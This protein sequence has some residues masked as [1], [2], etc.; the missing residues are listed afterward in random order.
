L[1][2]KVVLLILEEKAEKWETFRVKHFDVGGTYIL[3]LSI[4]QIHIGTERHG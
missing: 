2:V 4:E 3:A 1:L